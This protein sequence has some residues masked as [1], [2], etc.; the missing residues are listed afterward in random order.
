MQVN[1]KASEYDQE[2]AQSPIIGQTHGTTRKRQVT[3]TAPR[4]QGH[5]NP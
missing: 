4:Q 2:M 5:I 3:R 1:P